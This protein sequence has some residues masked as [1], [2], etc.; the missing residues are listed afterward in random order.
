[1]PK[2]ITL[3]V[4]ERLY[5]ALKLAAGAQNR[6]LSNYVETAARSY[7]VEDQFVSDE[8]MNEILADPSFQTNFKAALQ[9]IKKGRIKR[10]L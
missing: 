6:T 4:D 7:L 10:V 9:D 2:T 1:M 8:E 5:R 3:R